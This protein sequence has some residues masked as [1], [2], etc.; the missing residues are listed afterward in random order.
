M[1]TVFASEEVDKVTDNG[2]D[3]VTEKVT[4]NQKVIIELLNENNNYTTAE[5][6]QKVGISQRKVKEN[7]R[8]LK[9]KGLLKRIG[10]AKK[11]YWE[12]VVVS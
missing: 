11:G 8:K 12:I 2:T 1:V 3:K 9:E 7:L 4:E 5:L 10:S 6:A